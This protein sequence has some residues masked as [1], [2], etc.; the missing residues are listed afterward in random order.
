MWWCFQRNWC[1][2]RVFERWP[3]FLRRTF[4]RCRWDRRRRGRWLRRAVTGCR[5]FRN[6]WLIFI[7]LSSRPGLCFGSRCRWSFLFRL[8]TPV[9]AVLIRRRRQWSGRRNHLGSGRRLT[10][11]IHRRWHLWRL[12]SLG[13]SAISSRRAVLTVG[14]AGLPGR[15]GHLCI[16][17]AFAGSLSTLSAFWATTLVFW[18]VLND[19]RVL[20]RR[21]F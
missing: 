20:F 21:R 8:A 15:T 16:I 7:L 10:I 6:R 18:I 2:S 17:A 13:R 4:G 12:T 1:D 3:S 11:D 9:L 19:S 5:L 14:T